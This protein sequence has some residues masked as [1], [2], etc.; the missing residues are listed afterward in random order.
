MTCDSLRLSDEQ[1]KSQLELE[2]TPAMGL[3][4]M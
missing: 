3:N 1:S 2:S 4:V